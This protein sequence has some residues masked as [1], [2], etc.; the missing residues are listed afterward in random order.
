MDYK[1]GFA[2]L[3]CKVDFWEILSI[4]R[5]LFYYLLFRTEN[6]I[7]YKNIVYG[8]VKTRYILN[9]MTKQ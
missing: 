5:N 4:T 9:Q 7:E 1:K 8:S 6:K 3:F 2:R